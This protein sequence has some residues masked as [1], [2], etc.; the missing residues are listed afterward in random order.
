MVSFRCAPISL[1]AVA[2]VGFSEFFHLGRALSCH[3]PVAGGRV[4]HLVIVYGFHAGGRVV[5]LVIVYGFQG[6]STT[7]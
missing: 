1:P 2:T 6:G 5:H 3:L 4:V 7:S